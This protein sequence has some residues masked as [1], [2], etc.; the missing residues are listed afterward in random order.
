MTTSDS[1]LPLIA[2]V[3]TKLKATSAVTAFVG[4]RIYTSVPQPTTF[5][6][7]V[8][9]V[10]SAPFDTSDTMGMQHLVRVQGFSRVSSPAEALGIRA[11]VINTLERI[12]AANLPV[13]GYTLAYFDKGNL[14]DIITEDDGIT[15]QSIVEF[16]AVIM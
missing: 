16:N 6:Y 13:T 14:S 2:A 15:T 7:I 10:S 5:P 11:A 9:S 3:I 1:A 8:I 12:S 4:Q